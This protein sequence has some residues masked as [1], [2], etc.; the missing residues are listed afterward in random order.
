MLIQYDAN[1]V[2]IKVIRNVQE[3]Y[4]EHPEHGAHFTPENAK[5]VNPACACFVQWI[6]GIVLYRSIL[7]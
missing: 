4:T 2:P 6:C 1:N 3:N 7:E 5:K